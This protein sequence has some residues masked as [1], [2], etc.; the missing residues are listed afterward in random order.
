[1]RLSLLL[2]MLIC[3]IVSSDPPLS[4][5]RVWS[6]IFEDDFSGTSVDENKWLK[7]TGLWRDGIYTHDAL[8]V[9]NSCLT[10]NTYNDN[11]NYYTGRLESKELFD[12]TNVF[13]EVR[14]I[15]AKGSGMWSAFWINKDQYTNGVEIDVFEYF[16][17]TPAGYADQLQNAIHWSAA[18]TGKDLSSTYKYN[19]ASVPYYPGEPGSV[20]YKFTNFGALVTENQCRFYRNDTIH[21]VDN[22]PKPTTLQP[23]IIS[24][25]ISSSIA[26][27]I[28]NGT[29]E[30]NCNFIIDYVKV[31]K[32]ENK[33]PENTKVNYKLLME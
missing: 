19:Y 3:Q 1:M 31:W 17:Y 7:R 2:V 29:W 9:N 20:C 21:V 23:I 32:Y 24:C 4:D 16:A 33:F 30:E 11:D 14:C 8:T 25:E 18:V 13:V 28:D 22:L 27:D 6:L 26:G 12:L 5:N 15:P 10:I